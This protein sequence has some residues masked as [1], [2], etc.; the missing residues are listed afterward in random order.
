MSKNDLGVALVTGAS[1]GIGRAT[2]QR[3]AQ[4]GYRVFGTSRKA[5]AESAD[6]V[7][8]LICDV[9][10]DASV[11]KMVAEVLQQAGRVDVLVN[12]AGIGLLGGAEESSAAQAQALFD[13]NVFGITRVTNAVLPTMRSQRKGRIIN[14]SSILGLIPS[15]YN[16]LYS[17]TKHAVEGYSESLDHELRTFG[18]R[19]VLVE[20]GLTRTAFEESITRPDRSLAVYDAMRADMEALMR[21]GVSA[22][23]APEVVADTVLKA[24]TDAAPRRR[25]TSGKLA[26]QV[27]YLRRFL[28]ESVV[29]K[30]LRK[31]NNLPVREVRRVL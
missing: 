17:S 30:A 2:A 13:V 29:D 15:P 28:P 24:A 9:I 10:D 5:A 7:T 23:D 31:H 26:R 4:A 12:N 25:Y 8:M 11:R 1:S 27:S 3:L 22:G 20:P 14:M 6:G 18:I 19:V 21:K 16:A